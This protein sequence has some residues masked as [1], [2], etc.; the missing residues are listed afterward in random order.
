M[1]VSLVHADDAGGDL[2][3]SFGFAVGPQFDT[4]DLGPNNF[5]LIQFAAGYRSDNTFVLRE[6]YKGT[7][8]MTVGQTKV[9]AY[10]GTDDRFQIR[11]DR[12]RFLDQGSPIVMLTVRGV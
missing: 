2:G 12:I 9:F 4:E 1:P 10:E 6:K 3:K 8:D 5:G 7:G 11:F